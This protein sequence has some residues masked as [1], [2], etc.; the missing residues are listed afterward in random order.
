MI[1][2]VDNFLNEI[3]LKNLED[4]IKNKEYRLLDDTGNHVG[5]YTKY[6]WFIIS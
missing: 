2:I 4:T 3:E 5:E 6:R 1:T